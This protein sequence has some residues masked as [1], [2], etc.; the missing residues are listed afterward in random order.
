METD[1]QPS[2]GARRQRDNIR[3]MSA[4]R[5]SIF[6]DEWRADRRELRK[7]A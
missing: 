6:N 4:P 2:R 1:E 3:F 5:L 7:A